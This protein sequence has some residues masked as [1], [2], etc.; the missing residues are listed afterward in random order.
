MQVNL[1]NVEP[2]DDAYVANRVLQLHTNE[3]TPMNAYAPFDV[4]NAMLTEPSSITQPSH[5]RP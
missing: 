1:D 2:R 4:P 5:P 3:C